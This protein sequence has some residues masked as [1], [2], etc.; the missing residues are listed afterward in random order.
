MY[1]LLN[2]KTWVNGQHVVRQKKKVVL[3]PE[4][5]R[6][7]LALTDKANFSWATFLYKKNIKIIKNT[8]KIKK[9]FSGPKKF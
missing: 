8:L 3:F 6:Y 5:S 2:V 1:T 4:T 7:F 9:K